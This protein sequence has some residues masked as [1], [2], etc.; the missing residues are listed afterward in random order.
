MLDYNAARHKHL[1]S[2][3]TDDVDGASG[4]AEAK[5][6]HVRNGLGHLK[7]VV[8]LHLLL[9]VRLLIQYQHG[10]GQVLQGTEWSEVTYCGSR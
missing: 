5:Q 6:L 10:L 4:G 3:S 2:R 7:G 9:H 1:Y 8:L